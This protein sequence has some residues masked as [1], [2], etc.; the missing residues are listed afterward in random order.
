MI[1]LK[2]T[3]LILII[4]LATALNAQTLQSDFDEMMEKSNTYEKYKVI[5]KTRINSFWETV[6]DTLRDR[7]A[8]IKEQQSEI[9]GLRQ[10]IDTLKQQKGRIQASLND[11]N[12][13]NDQIEFAGVDFGKT[14]YHVLVWS[15]ILVLAIAAIVMY[16]IYARSNRTTGKVKKEHEALRAELSDH[17]DKSRE[18]QVRLKRELQTALN[19]IDEMKRGGTRRTTV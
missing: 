4:G 15:I 14:V 17:K 12:E 11:S 1:K 16:I 10:E 7:N 19:T 18:T 5:P 8:L 6:T 2:G 9:V 13:L 3:I